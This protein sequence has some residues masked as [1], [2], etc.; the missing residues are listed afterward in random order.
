MARTCRK[1]QYVT[2]RHSYT[3]M[4]EDAMNIAADTASLLVRLGFYSKQLRQYT[5]RG[6]RGVTYRHHYM[7][8]GAK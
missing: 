4:S 2:K 1:R 6:L 8:E 5:T 3:I 7:I